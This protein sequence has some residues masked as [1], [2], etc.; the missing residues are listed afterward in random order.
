MSKD[1]AAL[2]WIHALTPL[3]VGTDEGLGAINL[4]T[5]REAHTGHPILPG[6]SLKGV[7][8]AAET[9]EVR[10]SYLFGPARE[11]AGDHRGALSI[12]DARLVALPVRSLYGT[13]AWCTSV[14]VLRRLNRDRAEAGLAELT[15]PKEVRDTVR[16]ST[17][18]ALRQ[19]AR[20]EVFIE[21]FTATAESDEVVDRIAAALGAELWPDD[22]EAQA[23]LGRRLAVLPEDALN[24]LCRTA[25]ELR[26][27][28]SLDAAT[29]TAAAS[30]PWTEE[31]M[32][33]ETLLAALVVAQS[34]RVVKRDEKGQVVP[35]ALSADKA[36]SLF[37]ERGSGSVIRA[38]GHGSVGMGRAIARLAK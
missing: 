21:E 32:P 7:L 8:R 33:A 15:L 1:N 38:G 31:A 37:R 17:S 23:E 14:P 29:G 20:A 3:R 12:Y 24:A 35:D 27:R 13:F 4:P 10:Q 9:D 6:S 30:G 5:L 28:V 34:V 16:I 11:R 26:T 19:G 18:S 25:M 22:P 2:L 36:L